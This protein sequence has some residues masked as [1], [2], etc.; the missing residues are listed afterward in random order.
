[1]THRYKYLEQL[2]HMTHLDYSL[3][4]FKSD[5]QH[6]IESYETPQISSHVDISGISGVFKLFVVFGLLTVLLSLGF[7]IYS[8]I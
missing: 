7:V 3:S 2:H 8:I 4:E 6:K 1:M 5:S